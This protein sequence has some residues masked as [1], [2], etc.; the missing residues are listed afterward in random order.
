MSNEFDSPYKK[1]TFKRSF[2]EEKLENLSSD[3]EHHDIE[4]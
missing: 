3:S 1:V 4:R 2:L